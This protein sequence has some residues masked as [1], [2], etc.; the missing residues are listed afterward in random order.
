MARGLKVQPDPGEKKCEFLRAQWPRLAWLRLR[1]TGATT[2]ISG[3]AART[4]AQYR[5]GRT[6]QCPL[7]L[8]LPCLLMAWTCVAGIGRTEWLRS[9]LV[10]NDQAGEA[11]GPVVRAGRV[12][13]VAAAMPPLRCR[14]RM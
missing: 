9:Q 10:L 4:E 1:C 6:R 7:H 3:A 2:D 13:P 11:I 5:P 14:M 8:E 12:P